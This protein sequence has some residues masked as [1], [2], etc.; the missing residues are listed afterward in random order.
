[1]SHPRLQLAVGAAALLGEELPAAG[2]VR[3]FV[4]RGPSDPPAG[5]ATRLVLVHPPPPTGPARGRMLDR[6]AAI[7]STRHGGLAAPLATG[8]FGEATW[9]VEARPRTATLADRVAGGTPLSVQE[10][11]RILREAARA[12]SA[13]HRVG[14]VHGA[15]DANAIECPP[16]AVVLHQLGHCDAGDA[17]NDLHALGRLGWLALTGREPAPDDRRLLAVRQGVPAPLDDLVAALL[18]TDPVAGTTSVEAILETL[19]WFPARE[20][21]PL[22]T[23]IDGAGRGARL[24]GERR[25]AVALAIVGIALMLL[26]VLTRKG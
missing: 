4:A 18:E 8:Q 7:R 17:Q 11:V 16:D 22:R 13:L 24:P 20:P 15:L 19:D 25:T 14:L 2:E 21:T 1:M 23:L 10:T 9:V 26:W 5:P 3:R 6:M 12:L